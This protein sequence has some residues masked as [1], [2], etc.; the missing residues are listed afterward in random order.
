MFKSMFTKKEGHGNPKHMTFVSFVLPMTS[1]PWAFC[2][3]IGEFEKCSNSLYMF[4]FRESFA[5]ALVKDGLHLKAKLWA[6]QGFFAGVLQ[7]G[8]GSVRTGR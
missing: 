8:R 7:F 1:G 4:I 2:E 3:C 6:C 5:K